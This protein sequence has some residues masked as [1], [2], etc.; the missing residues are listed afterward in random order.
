MWRARWSLSHSKGE[1]ACVCVVCDVCDVDDQGEA[2]FCA[3]LALCSVSSIFQRQP[4]PN[5]PQATR[6]GPHESL[7]TGHNPL[8]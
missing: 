5:D 1:W 8:D 6:T 7:R 3:Q 2:Q 4:H